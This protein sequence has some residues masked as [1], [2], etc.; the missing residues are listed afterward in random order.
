MLLSVPGATLNMRPAPLAPD[1]M[2]WRQTPPPLATCPGAFRLRRGSRFTWRKEC[3]AVME[4]WV[5]QSKMHFHQDLRCVLDKS[6]LDYLETSSGLWRQR[7]E[8]S[9]ALLLFIATS[10]TTS[11]RTKPRGRRSP[12]PATL[13]FRNQVRAERFT[14]HE[15]VTP[16]QGLGFYSD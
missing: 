15:P 3:L 1:E 12:T 11:I 8:I 14:S 13:W 2:E 5:P 6:G 7:N 9:V 10:M 16:G 4:R